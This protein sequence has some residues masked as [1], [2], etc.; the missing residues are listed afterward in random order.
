MPWK[1][2][3]H[4]VFLM[5]LGY[6]ACFFFRLNKAPEPFAFALFALPILL[7][8]RAKRSFRPGRPR[9]ELSASDCA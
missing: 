6:A 1:Q 8:L 4:D 9:S 3:R 5:F 2:I 7:A